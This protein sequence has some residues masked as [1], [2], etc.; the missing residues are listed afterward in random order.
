MAPIVAF[1]VVGPLLVYYWLSANG[2]S[3]VDALIVSGALPACNVGLTVLRHRRL[4]AIGALVLTGIVV[5]SVLGLLSGSARVVLLDG[6]VPTAIFGLVCLGSLWSTRPLMFRFAVESI[7]A[8]TPK[9]LAFADKWRYAEF[10]QAFRITTIVW[11][12]AYLVEAV[13][14]MIIVEVASSGVAKTTSTVL[15]WICTAALIVW[16]VAYARRGQQRGAAAE[17]AA[18]A[19]SDGF[20]LMPVEV[21]SPVRRAG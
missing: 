15:P 10:R 12:L 4:D 9:G 7:G 2:F 5:G 20:P 6:T 11:G 3:T 16:N 21:P 18:R 14:Q 13:V 8:D 19:R 17:A 1:D